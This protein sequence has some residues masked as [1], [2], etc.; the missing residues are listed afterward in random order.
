ML[1]WQSK[2]LYICDIH[3]STT[4]LYRAPG[5][6]LLELR[7]P[8]TFVSTSVAPPSAVSVAKRTQFLV[9]SR[10]LWWL[11]LSG[12]SCGELSCGLL[13]VP[14][15][16]TQQRS[17]S[18]LS[19]NWIQSVRRWRRHPGSW[20]EIIERQT[21]LWK[22]PRTR[23]WLT[24]RIRWTDEVNEKGNQGPAGGTDQ[25]LCISDCWFRIASFSHVQK[26][27]FSH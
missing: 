3:V 13:D 18:T 19:H 2:P 26:R 1:I 27:F 12:Y 5:E 4:P 6:L 25:C 17:L 10:L 23:F 14:A 11:S 16:C 8:W 20:Q 15:V 9:D 7:R 22:P 24:V 21:P